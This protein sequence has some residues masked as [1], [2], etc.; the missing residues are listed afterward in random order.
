MYIHTSR[1]SGRARYRRGGENRPSE[2]PKTDSYTGPVYEPNTVSN[3][4][5]HI[6]KDETPGSTF[7][8]CLTFRRREMTDVKSP[9]PF[10]MSTPFDTALSTPIGAEKSV[11]Y[12]PKLGYHFVN[13]SRNQPIPLPFA[14]FPSRTPVPSS[15]AKSTG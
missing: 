5:S 15:I 11:P 3:Q 14:S 13:D 2:Q 1:Q 4:V 8:S 12:Y 10:A 6:V 9:M 7:V